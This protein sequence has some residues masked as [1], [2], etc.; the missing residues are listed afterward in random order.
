MSAISSPT[1]GTQLSLKDK[2]VSLP[3]SEN[4][5]GTSFGNYEFKAVDPGHDP[6]FGILPLQF[7][8]GHLAV[9]ILLFAPATMF[10]L[11]GAFPFYEIDIEH[12]VI[13]YKESRQDAW[14]E[15]RPKVEESE[16]ARSYFDHSAAASGSAVR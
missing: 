12:G 6:F 15:Y 2:T 4:L 5:R 7:K 10:N 8:G 13:R 1:P 16:R 11:R 3:A 9:D 14:T